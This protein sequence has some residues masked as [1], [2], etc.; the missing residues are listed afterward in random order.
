MTSTKFDS[1][2]NTLNQ[3]RKEI[4]EKKRPEYTEGN[5]DVLHNF[6]MVAK[7]IGVTPIQAWYIYFRKHVASIS[8]F[9][10]DPKRQLAEPIQGRIADAMNYLELL[11][12]LIEEE[13]TV[14]FQAG[15]LLSR[16]PPGTV[17]PVIHPLD[18][19]VD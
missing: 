7:E 1:L 17:I 13:N 14:P 6:K 10:K 8:Q 11:Y 15:I 16:P 19:S 9:G 5:E 18:V 4:V 3:S 2:I 12:A